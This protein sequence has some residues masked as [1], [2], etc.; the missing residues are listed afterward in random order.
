M[1]SPTPKCRFGAEKKTGVPCSLIT[2]LECF[3]L[4]AGRDIVT[5]FIADFPPVL[6]SSTV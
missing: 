4:K 3:S 2:P 5:S 6:Q 1:L